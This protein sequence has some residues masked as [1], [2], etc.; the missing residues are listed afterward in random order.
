MGQREKSCFKLRGREINASI[1]AGVEIARKALP[2]GASGFCEVANR[3]FAKVEAKHGTE[4]MKGDWPSR[5]R[6]EDSFFELCPQFFQS[7]PTFS[8]DEF[9]D[10]RETS[11]QRSRERE[12]M[13][14]QGACPGA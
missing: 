6:G 8:L 5:N 10:L 12:R 2:V 14:R 7:R 11:R 9:I 3:S 13:S 1:Q 4:A